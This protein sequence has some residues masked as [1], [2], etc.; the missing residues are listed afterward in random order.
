MRRFIANRHCAPAVI[1]ATLLLG[2]CSQDATTAKAPPG[3]MEGLAAQHAANEA[4]AEVEK[5]E[6]AHAR[7]AERAADARQKLKAKAG[8]D[9]FEK[10]E[11]AAETLR[12][13]AGD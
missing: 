8:I 11:Q 7:E 1:A 12:R 3:A 13:K 5:V 6:A 2:A 10:A 9:G 4:A